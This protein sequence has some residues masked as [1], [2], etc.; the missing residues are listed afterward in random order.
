MEL[1][2]LLQIRKE[3]G[4]EIAKTGKV[5]MVGDKW[6]VPSQSS[7]KYYSVVL[8][9][10]K[11]VCNCPDFAERGLKCKHIFSVEITIRQVAFDGTITETKKIT[12]PQNWKAYN[13]AQ[14]QQKDLFMKLLADMCQ[15]IPDDPTPRGKGRPKLPLKDMVFASGLKVFTTFSLRRF[16]SDINT[17][18][19]LGY[20][21]RTPHFSMVSSYMEKEELTPILKELITLSSMP[22]RSVETRFAIDS[23]GLRTTKFTEYCHL[24]HNTTAE[25]QWIKVHVCCGV[26]TNIITG[27]EV[28]LGGHRNG[29]DSPQFVPLA[30][31]TFESGFKIE[32]MY[33]DKAYSSKQN[34]EFI[35]EIGGTAYIPFKDIA[36]RIGRNSYGLWRKMYRYFTYNREEFMQHYHQRSNVESTFNMIKSKFTDL[37]RSKNETAQYNE[38]LLKVLCHNISV[39]IQEMFELGIEPNFLQGG[40]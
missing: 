25:H 37:I 21:E 24:R 31:K 36:G 29:N 38:V 6:L 20:I 8:G 40:A 11:S 34:F 14:T 22:L 39:L 18:K 26:K 7:N 2:Q 17:A 9:I 5:K 13:K 33:A 32:E 19:Q 10:D 28:S 27:V 15:T 23:S 30:K 3:K 12:Y 4:K 1:Q 16:M 35:N